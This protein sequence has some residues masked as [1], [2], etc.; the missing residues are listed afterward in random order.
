MHTH[1]HTHTCAQYNVPSPTE[2]IVCVCVVGVFIHLRIRLSDRNLVS[3]GLPYQSN[4][5]S[6]GILFWSPSLLGNN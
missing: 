2:G 6:S 1:T 4:A 5:N 3:I